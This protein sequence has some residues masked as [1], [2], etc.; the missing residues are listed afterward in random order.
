V[1]TPAGK[2]LARGTDTANWSFAAFEGGGRDLL[3][4]TMENA[5]SLRPLLV[6][7]AVLRAMP[8]E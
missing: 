7:S 5:Y 2:T 4:L 6:L 8:Q 1:R 3:S